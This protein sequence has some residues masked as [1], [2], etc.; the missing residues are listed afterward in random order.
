VRPVITIDP[1]SG[2]PSISLQVTGEQDA[3][4][5]LEELFSILNDRSASRPVVVAID[6]FQQ[7][8]GYPEGNAEALLRGMIS[9]LRK[10]RFIFSGSNKSMLLR[11]FGDATRPFYQSSEMMF[12]SE[13]PVEQYRSFIKGLFEEKGRLV[14]VDVITELLRWCRGHTWYV[15]FTANR[16]F[17][18]GRNIDTEN[19]RNTIREI[20]SGNEPFYLEFRNL[21]TR[22]QWQLLRAIASTDGIEKLT[23]GNFIRRYNLTNASTV[24]RSVNSLI[25]KEMVFRKEDKYYVYDVFL[26]RWLE[27]ISQNV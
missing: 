26:A 27:M 17:E 21:L 16:L 18:T 15:Q 12:L 25:D 20:I 6:E 11:M 19:L 8:A 1:L 10:V 23:S 3:R 5:T 2:L 7:I 14:D 22:H 9:T 24:K 13:I 4:G